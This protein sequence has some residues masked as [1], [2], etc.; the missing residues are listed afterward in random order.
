[1]HVLYSLMKQSFH[2]P[3]RHLAYYSGGS[4]FQSWPKKRPPWLMIGL[5][6]DLLIRS[7]AAS[8]ENRSQI[9]KPSALSVASLTKNDFLSVIFGLS[10]SF[11]HPCCCII[12]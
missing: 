2:T 8:G 7:A 3:L 12:I 11:L 5:Y 4:R 10:S 6:R 9:D 1:M